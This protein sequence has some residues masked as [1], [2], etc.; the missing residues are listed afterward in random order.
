[1]LSSIVGGKGVGPIVGKR[2]VNE[3]TAVRVIR[4][5]KGKAIGRTVRA[6]NINAINLKLKLLGCCPYKTAHNAVSNRESLHTC[7]DLFIIM[8]VSPR[9]KV[10]VI[11]IQ[12]CR[13]A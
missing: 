11:Y 9:N 8:K 6:I 3:G 4:I 10:A 1:M 2:K 12:H 7:P 13:T 5:D